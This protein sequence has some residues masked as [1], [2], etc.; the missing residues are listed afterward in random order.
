M[1]AEALDGCSRSLL[2]ALCEHHP[3][4]A[5]VILPWQTLANLASLPA[6]SLRSTL[7][8]LAPRHIELTDSLTDPGVWLHHQGKIAGFLPELSQPLQ[9]CISHNAHY[10]FPLHNQP[11]AGHR[12]CTSL[13]EQLLSFVKAL[14]LS[15]MS[16]QFC[17]RL[18]DKAPGTLRSCAAVEHCCE[19]ITRLELSVTLSAEAPLAFAS[20]TALERLHLITGERCDEAGAHE[21]SLMEALGAAVS[22]LVALTALTWQH[23]ELSEY[24]GAVYAAIC[25]LPGLRDLALVQSAAAMPGCETLARA[26][27]LTRLHLGCQRLRGHGARGAQARLPALLELPSLIAFEVHWCPIGFDVS[28]LSF[29]GQAMARS[30][31]HLR[32]LELDGATMSQG[33]GPAL[34]ACRSLTRLLLSGE[35]DTPEVSLYSVLASAAP[36]LS[37]LQSLHAGPDRNQRSSDAIRNARHLTVALPCLTALTS[38][39]MRWCNLPSACQQGGFA[40][41]LAGLTDLQCLRVAPCA[42]LH[43]LAPAL[44]AL[45]ALN[46]LGVRERVAIDGCEVEAFVGGLAARLA[47]GP[48]C[49]TRFEVSGVVHADVW[50]A[51]KLHNA[52]VRDAAAHNAAAE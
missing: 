45:T 5:S 47:H 21:Q 42:T 3:W 24:A 19:R 13:G 29:S 6:G 40:R 10:M 25:A 28:F 26:C 43:A 18:P 30:L 27:Q 23:S 44:G 49:R 22:G 17:L 33:A 7:A 14:D 35:G 34:R 38:L 41:T 39:S 15:R 52:V 11:A 16:L 2:A 46:V 4:L 51:L 32:V 36:G 9:L 48:L 37:A 8:L 1:A 12:E 50:A 31:P 20:C